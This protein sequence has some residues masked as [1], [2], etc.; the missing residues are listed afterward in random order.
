MDTYAQTR[1]NAAW[2]YAAGREDARDPFFDAWPDK[3]LCGIFATRCG[4]AAQQYRDGALN[5]LPSVTDQWRDFADTY[6]G[7][8]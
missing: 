3:D 4:E 7:G 2:W 6:N 8:K 1:R 5:S